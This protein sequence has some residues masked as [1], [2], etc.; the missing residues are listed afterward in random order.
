MKKLTLIILLL[1]PSFISAQGVIEVRSTADNA[2][3]GDN[4]L[5]FYRLAIPVTQSALYEDFDGDYDAVLVFWRE[6][7]EFVNEVFV[8][9]GFCFDVIEDSR[10]VV[11]A[12]YDDYSVFELDTHLLDEVM[13]TEDYDIGMWVT[14]RS[15]ESENTG[16]SVTGGAYSQS[17]KATGY[18]KADCWVVAHEIGHLLGADHTPPGEG[19]LMDNTGCFL[20]LPSLK[21]I[22]EA[23]M[24][25]NA[26]YYADEQ[27]TQLVGINDG[28]NYVYGVK[29]ANNAPQFNVSDM[30]ERYRMPEGACLS[31]ELS[32]D[33]VDNDR[34]AYMAI[35]DD[36]EMIASVAPQESNIVDY[37][38][39]FSA[40]IY[41][42]EY[43]Y[44]VMG[45]D[46]PALEPGCYGLN[47]V[48]YDRPSDFSLAS[49]KK[50]P[51]YCNYAVWEAVVEVVD[52]TPFEAK[53]SPAEECYTAGERVTVEWGVNGSCFSA[54]SRVC[55][56]MSTD[57]GKSYSHVL[58]GSV[59]ASDGFCVVE[60]PDVNVGNVDVDF[61]TATHSM[62]GGVVRVEEVGG[63]A[64]TLTAISPERG[65]S[66]NVTGGAVTAV[67]NVLCSDASGEVYDLCGRSVS[68]Q[69]VVGLAPGVYIVGGNKI[70]VK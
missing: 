62:P 40:D 53:L 55:I 45:T 44:P 48:V 9:A 61:I 18:A 16:Q 63:V 65:G 66:F 47:F 31:V 23:S 20:S 64:Y 15:G 34:L 10:L 35:G 30:Q 37:R 50:T 22:R 57:Y 58:A 46:I 8:P 42:P 2:I 24:S 17:T 3:P 1:F 25:R 56:T 41:Y 67:E 27:R 6:C 43:Y 13:D 49:M 29:V 28:G 54:D 5:R 7:E 14:H 33:D 32:V 70:V 68:S 39:Q 19:S 11:P 52:G 38:P 12:Q 26:A 69:G 59:P 60:L 51:F 21:K 36:V 4:V